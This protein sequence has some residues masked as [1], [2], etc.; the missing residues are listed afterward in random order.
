MVFKMAGDNRKSG[1]NI[2]GDVP[3][4][5]HFCQFYETPKDLTDI[6]VPYFKAGL[7]GNEYCMWVTA[8]PLDEKSAEKAI[9]KAMSDFDRY[10]EK[11]QIEIVPHDQWYLKGGVFDLQ[12][13]LG[14][15]ID[16]LDHALKQGYDGL[17]VTSN[18]AWLEKKDWKSFTEYAE[19]INRVIGNYRM[20]AICTYSLDRC[21]AAEVIDVVS[22]HQ[23]AL[24]RRQGK[25]QLMEST[26][27]KKQELKLRESQK[28]F[29]ALVE[30]TGDFIWEMNLNGVYTYCSPQ[31]EKLWGLKPE[32][33]LGKTPF[34]LLPPEDRE[35]AIKAFSALS[36]SS[37]PFMKMEVRSLDGTGRIKFLEISGVPFFDIAGKQYGYR[38]ITRDITER[39]QAEENLKQ[40]ELKYRR[41]VETAMEG[42]LQTDKDGRIVF[43][44][45]RTLDMLGYAEQEL[46]GQPYEKLKFAEDLPALMEHRK[47]R[48]QGIPGLLESRYKRKNGSEIWV[49]ISATVIKDE[50]GQFDGIFN[51]I[52]DIT[53]R[54]RLEEEQRKVAKLE[55]IGLL[56]G[57]IAH[58][59]NNILTAIMGN[60]GLAKMETE[61]G[62]ELHDRMEEAEKASLRAKSLTQQLLTFSK[63]GA[64]VKKLASLSELLRETASFALRGSSVKCQF[65][66]AD[67]LWDAEIDEGQVSQVINNLVINA[68][69]AMPSGGTIEVR[70]ENIVLAK[71]QGLGKNLPLP[72]GK[73]AR[74]VFT[75]HGIGIPEAQIDKI[76]DPFFTTKQTGSG[77][78]LS[79][80][81]SII[82]NHGGHIGVES[83]LGVGSTFYIYLPA[84]TKTAA[85]AK[86]EERETIK[87]VSK[88]R[89]LVMDDEE[90]VREIASR[91]LKHIG[92][93]DIKLAIDGTE[94]I[95]IYSEAL[96]AGKPFDVVILDLTIPGGMGGKETIKKL[97]E[98]NPKV[99]AIVSSGYSSELDVA[100]Y[101][102]YGFKGAVGKPYTI[103]QL[104]QAMRELLG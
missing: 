50:K 46:I 78:G 6:L 96:K 28:R 30:T 74:I 8:E 13:V 14:S 104:G 45:R 95:K 89:I 93:E 40:S 24:I 51:L 55:S 42:I 38:G 11:G 9:R 20:I 58:D 75:D 73:Y 37:S 79:T 52:T 91:M 49:F 72:E 60:I 64:P 63:G 43:T 48:R 17:R 25:W 83:T 41:I 29:Q 15:W 3:W 56:A 5:T 4:G 71:E 61:P 62:S 44:N 99:K 33:M 54:R 36:E 66:I 39:K 57:G 7:E 97:L 80:S 81:F 19:E 86:K 34:D 1:L 85:T 103:E 21:G 2:I 31:I 65:S 67:D 16:K 70:A 77:L 94:A 101:K 82:H 98:I 26:E 27:H 76:F 35:Q 100:E 68:R 88:C 87:P 102:G 84:S 90:T 23:F 10:L 59:F 69:Q 53:E 32:E 47:E 22:N 92:Y 12:M 18:T